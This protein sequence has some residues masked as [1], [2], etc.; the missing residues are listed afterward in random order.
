MVRDISF[1]VHLAVCVSL[2]Q[3]SGCTDT[4][5]S[6]S[7]GS[8]GV[9]GGSGGTHAGGK[10]GAGGTSAPGGAGGRGTLDGGGGSGPAPLGGH[11][12]LG[13]GVVA[14][15]GPAATGGGGLASVGGGGPVPGS[16]APKNWGN[17]AQTVTL[18]T[19]DN[20]LENVSTSTSWCHPTSDGNLALWNSNGA[21]ESDGAVTFADDAVQGVAALSLD[22]NTTIEQP[23]PPTPERDCMRSASPESWTYTTWVRNRATVVNDSG[24]M[25]PFARDYYSTGGGSGWWLQF[26]GLGSGVG[27]VTGRLSLCGWMDGP[28]G[29]ISLECKNDVTDPIVNDGEW[30]FV[31]AQYTGEELRLAVEGG[32][33]TLGG[34]AYALQQ[35]QGTYAWQLGHKPPGGVFDVDEVW[36]TSAQLSLSQ[37]CRVR[38][39]GVQGEL[40]WCEGATW[41]A[42]EAD[43]QCG[44][45]VG[46]CNHAFDPDG[47]GPST[48]TCV[49]RLGV[50]L[51]SEAIPSTC[52]EVADLGACDADL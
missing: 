6:G 3:A 22:G 19:F 14:G 48:G 51:A 30:R 7:G 18:L 1:S 12:A 25:F 38:S 11:S 32:N 10:L 29:A 34:V 37:A 42:C 46:A 47:A 8:S 5:P 17:N 44:G 31:L 45:R 40:G 21:W 43:A 52:D 49:G 27:G 13:G 50:S 35:N 20:T 36:W 39:V 15:G 26:V 9:L 41:A 24:Y 23:P 33:H 4:S 16:E 28:S 2:L